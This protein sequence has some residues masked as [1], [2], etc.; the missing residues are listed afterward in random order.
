M[1]FNFYLCF[2]IIV[3]SNAFHVNSTII[4][5]KIIRPFGMRRTKLEN[6]KV[7]EK[8]NKQFLLK[9]QA[10]FKRRKIINEHLMPLTRGNK[11]MK[12]FYSGR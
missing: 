12:D 5:Q 2:Y 7:F 6:L 8:Y 3:L 4:L 10:E 11:F 9:E 1:N